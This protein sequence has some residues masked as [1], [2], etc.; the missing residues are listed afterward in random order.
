MSFVGRWID[1]YKVLKVG[2][3]SAD[4][5]IKQLSLQFVFNEA[6]DGIRSRQKLL[7]ML[8]LNS[9][10]L[11]DWLLTG[12]TDKTSPGEGFVTEVGHYFLALGRTCEQM[13][14]NNKRAK[15]ENDK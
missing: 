5:T 11:F 7:Q 10:F 15:K 8:T 9:F 4:A 13:N 12:Q 14:V 6:S 1:L 3:G 2:N